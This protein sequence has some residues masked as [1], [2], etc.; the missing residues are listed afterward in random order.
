MRTYSL[1]VSCTHEWSESDSVPGFYTCDQC[2]GVF[3]HEPAQP[4]D[5]C[6]Q[7]HRDLTAMGKR[8]LSWAGLDP[9]RARIYRD[10]LA[11]L[12]GH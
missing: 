11:G 2:H 6:H 9:V 1:P 8:H 10:T 3:Y 4:D 5:P 12:P 7:R